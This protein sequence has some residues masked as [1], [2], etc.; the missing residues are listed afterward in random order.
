MNI[1]IKYILIWDSTETIE[2]Y[3]S[4]HHYMEDLIRNI[5]SIRA[6]LDQAPTPETFTS[7]D[8]LMKHLVEDVM[9]RSMY[10]LRICVSLAPSEKAGIKGYT[11]HRAVIL[12]HMV[13]IVKLYDGF[14]MH[15]AKRQLELAEIFIRLINE[16]VV[17]MLYILRCGNQKQAIRSFILTSYKAERQSIKDLKSKQA[18]RPLIPIE[19]R[20]LRS[21]TRNIREDGI[22]QKEL[23]SNK[24]WKVDGKDVA[25]MLRHLGSE[26]QYS[27]GFGGSSRF[28]HGNWMEMKRRHLTRNG[29]YYQPKL[30]FS[31]P[32]LRIATPITIE[33][34]D[35]SLK[36]LHWS[37]ADPDN[38][39]KG[40]IADFIKYV[41]ILDKYHE[42]HF[43]QKC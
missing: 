40:L 36:Y 37:K 9:S 41:L 26:W 4:T 28:I 11:K 7:E 8:S 16:T 43:M 21:M 24:N 18:Q 27:Y 6:W 42:K 34:L 10:L 19:K 5:S 38:F 14:C 25:S 23:F 1:A 2:Y 22:T 30:T 15:V 29:A 35:A 39:V 20:M 12:G 3:V 31:D 13:R 33:V 17:R 32:D